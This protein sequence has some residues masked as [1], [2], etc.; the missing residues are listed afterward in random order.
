[1]VSTDR[2]PEDTVALFTSKYGHFVALKLLKYTSVDQ[3]TL[4]LANV[5]P[6]I[7]HLVKNRY[8]A[9]VLNEFYLHYA[10]AEEK[11]MVIKQCYGPSL[12][13]LSDASETLSEVFEKHPE[14][15]PHILK[16]VS[17]MTWARKLDPG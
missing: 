6:Q 11:A 9:I 16:Y 5:K 3:K 7:A 14:K 10:T 4:L 13:T 1:M 12:Q 2:S 15:K 17:E 8:S